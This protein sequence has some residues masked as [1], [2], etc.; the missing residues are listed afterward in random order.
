MLARQRCR[1]REGRRS[2][3]LTR[4]LIPRRLQLRAAGSDDADRALAV[5]HL[6]DVALA[7]ALG[8]PRR[9][10]VARGFERAQFWVSGQ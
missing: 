3:R 1:S 8:D 7:L 6:D 4:P 2:L 10:V 5:P 9:L